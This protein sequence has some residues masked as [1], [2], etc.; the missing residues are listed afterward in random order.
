M[1]KITIQVEKWLF[2]PDPFTDELLSSWLTRI[3]KANFTTVIGLFS[4]HWAGKSYFNKD[5]DIYDYP[6][7]FWQILSECTGISI[8]Q[9]YKMRLKS[10]EGYIQESIKSFGKQRWLVTTSHD[11]KYNKRI[12]SLCYC[13]LCLKENGYYKKEWKLYF[14]NAC[15]KHCCLLES[16]CPKCGSPLAPVYIQADHGM[17]ICFKCGASLLDRVPTMIPKYSEGLKAIRRLL[18]IAKRGYFLLNGRW[19]Y[20]M[21]YFYVLRIFARHVSHSKYWKKSALD[22]WKDHREFPEYYTTQQM[23]IIIKRAVEL[24]Q[25]WPRQ[26]QY[27][28]KRHKL[29]NKPRLLERDERK[30]SGK[31]LP[32]WLIQALDDFVKVISPLCKEEVN[33]IKYYLSKNDKLTAKR[34]AEI[35]GYQWMSGYRY[36]NS[37]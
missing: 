5:I 35:T 3:A 4:Q 2:V 11:I 10:Y 25:N 16:Q 7:N 31:N 19:Y 13:P 18:S 1:N 33:S 36:L 12:R 32:F 9:I 30:N 15:T 24:F 28:F 20:S 27:F 34:F 14:V 6:E 26:F 8:M 37:F 17:E 21:S 22:V 23:F 29:T